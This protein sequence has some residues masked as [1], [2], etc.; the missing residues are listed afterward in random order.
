MD[1]EIPDSNKKVSCLSRKTTIHLSFGIIRFY[2]IYRKIR[3]RR[4]QELGKRRITKLF[5]SA[6]AGGSDLFE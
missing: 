3:N 5:D 6:D 4:R 2:F 1:A